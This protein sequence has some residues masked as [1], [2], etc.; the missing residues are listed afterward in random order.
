MAALAF[1]L[2]HFVVK[3]AQG[4][5]LFTTGSEYMLLGVLVGPAVVDLIDEQSLRQLSPLM[6]LAIGWVGLLYGASLNPQKLLGDTSG[7]MMVSIVASVGTF[8]LVFGVAWVALAHPWL[9]AGEDRLMGALVL[10]VAA[11]ATA[12]VII[13]LV[14]VRFRAEG[15]LTSTLVQ[16][17]RL[18]E[19]LAIAAFGAIFAAF[20]Q[21]AEIPWRDTPITRPEWYVI[22]VG[23][24]LLLGGLFRFFLKDEQDADKQ[25]LS[26]VGIIVF[27]SGA[28]HYL[29]LSPLLINMALGFSMLFNARDA[30]SQAL[31]EVL[32]RTRGPMY[33]VLLIF[34]G[35]MWRP[36][37]LP[38]FVFAL[39]YAL[40]RG[41]SRLAAGWFSALTAGPSVRRDIGRGMLGQG[42]V[43]VAMA[44]NFQLVYSDSPVSALVVTAVLAS[45]LLNELWSARLLK[46]L[47]I[48]AG[49]IRAEGYPEPEVLAEGG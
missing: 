25:F 46:G 34:A 45:V 4:R 41:G 36:V 13:Q 27:S 15:E 7:S 18:A 31:L 24:G 2:F 23:L 11:M 19:F 22:S 21:E 8:G 20:R 14:K 16:S 12:P 40:L 43:A 29:E 1:L 44:L 48:D 28:A 49:D 9:G 47:L 30:S 32:E 10:G 39:A 3:W 6:S 38:I 42:E 37:A 33:I 17:S 35:A 26:L 5:F